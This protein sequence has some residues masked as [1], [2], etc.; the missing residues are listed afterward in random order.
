MLGVWQG[1]PFLF[2]DWIHLWR[3]RQPKGPTGIAYRGYAAYMTLASIFTLFLQKP[4]W[5]IFVY[6]VTGALFFPFIIATL[7]W[8]NNRKA[9]LPAPLRNSLAVNALLALG[10]SLFVYLGLRRFF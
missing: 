9:W 6:T 7:L 8:M 3:R 5:L 4:V 2:D 1:V 10:L